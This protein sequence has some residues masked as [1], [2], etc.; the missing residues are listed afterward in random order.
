MFR[1]YT[2]VTMFLVSFRILNEM[3]GE[4][5][6]NFW[7]E[8]LEGGDRSQKFSEGMVEVSW[9]LPGGRA[10][11]KFNT[12]VTF[13]NL[14]GDATKYKLLTK[15]LSKLSTV[16]CIFAQTTKAMHTFLKKA[17]GK[18]SLKRIIVV[19]LYKPDDKDNIQRKL[20]NLKKYLRKEA[21]LK[22][23]EI[24]SHPF[25]ENQF[26]DTQS[27]L[28]K[29]LK[30]SINNKT[31]KRKSLSNII[32]DLK[33]VAE[34]DDK[35]CYDGHTAAQKI[36]HDIDEIG[37]QQ[38]Y[39]V[40]SEVLPCES[41]TVTREKIG[42]LDKETFRYKDI[43]EKEDIEQYASRKKEEKW[44][45]QWQQL[46]HE[47]SKIFANFLKYI[48][49]FTPLNRKYFLRSL[50]QG[51]NDRTTDIL[52]PLYVAYEKCLRGDSVGK[53]KELNEKIAQEFPGIAT[54]LPRNG[55]D[56]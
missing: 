30:A 56:V 13:A 43:T 34:V 16:T 55:S 11:D 7:H 6:N 32:N 44:Q 46:Q 38:T 8:G 2:W 29:A 26:F 22:K 14:R 49:N 36:L 35:L 28:L 21:Y 39:S 33:S 1:A 48:V 19:L 41:D 25:E 4:N 5:L 31:D 20:K 9:Y 53:R 37:S 47:M 42:K 52:Q 40:K 24:I 50:K 54:F 17:F 12:P 45:L 23:C 15:K 27:K 3:L 18:R 51:L 10:T